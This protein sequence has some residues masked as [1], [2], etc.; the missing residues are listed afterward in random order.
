MQAHLVDL[1]VVEVEVGVVMRGAPQGVGTVRL[2]PM[3]TP[4]DRRLV[5]Q[6][7]P[8]KSCLNCSHS[9]FDDVCGGAG[10]I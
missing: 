1:V 3:T 10:T 2:S 4:A 7:R 5:I 9:R 6:S 8:W